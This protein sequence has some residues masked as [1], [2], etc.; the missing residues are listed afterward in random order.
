MPAP[1]TQRSRGPRAYLAA[2]T[3]A[4]VLAL[5]GGAGNAQATPLDGNGMWIWYVSASGGS[6]EAIAKKANKRN[7]GTVMIK[8]GDATN[9]WEQFSPRLVSAL[10]DAGLQVC[11][12][13]FVY[14]GRPRPEARI[15]AKAVSN[16]ADCLLIDAESH[17][18]GRHRAADRYIDELRQR[19]GKEYPVGLASFPYVDFHSS[20]PYSV[21]LGPGA[22][23]YNVPQM[24]WKTI[25]TSVRNIYEHTYKVNAPFDRPIFPLGQTYLNVSRKSVLKFRKFALRYDADGVSWWSWQETKGKEWRWVGKPLDAGAGKARASSAATGPR[26]SYATVQGGDSGDLVVWAQQL[27]EGHGNSVRI[28]GTY[29]DGMVTAVRAFQ[30]D[31]GLTPSGEIDDRTWT[32]LLRGDPKRVDWSRRGAPGGPRIPD[33][34]SLPALRFELPLTPGRP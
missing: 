33:S 34:A 17:Y 23:Q 21:F 14:G 29:D 30:V 2:L 7:I 19:V 8:S 6:A 26:P 10:H 9:Y 28:D 1:P 18:E 5:G 32:A 20:F 13:Q 12:W 11:A 16:G 25:G 4:W 27:L 31:A 22:A 3:V 24:Y 15:G